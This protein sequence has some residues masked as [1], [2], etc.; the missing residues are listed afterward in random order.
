MTKGEVDSSKGV[1]T[2]PLERAKNNGAHIVPL[3]T[4]RSLTFLRP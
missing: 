3:S 2:I 1:W 4:P